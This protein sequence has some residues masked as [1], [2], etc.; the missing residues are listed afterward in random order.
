MLTKMNECILVTQ[1][2][3]LYDA[4]KKFSIEV[5]YPEELVP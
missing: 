5:K 1:D 4:A 3:E 2:K